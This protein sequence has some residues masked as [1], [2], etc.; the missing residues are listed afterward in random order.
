[1]R[2]QKEYGVCS[3]THRVYSLMVLLRLNDQFP[4]LLT[5]SV[6]GD[7]Y[8][9]LAQVRDAI[10]ASQFPDGHWPS[11]WPDGADAVAHPA[12]DDLSK[13]VIA[14]GH[15]L[16]WLAIAPKD[17]HP[18][19]EQIRKAFRW[20]IDTTTAQTRKEILDR[21]TFFSHVGSAGA[22]W[23]STTPVEFQK[24]HSATAP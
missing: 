7:V 6:R 14:T 4:G 24:T 2:G 23:R 15:H 19:E 8:N 5:E 3:G 17:L 10:T 9:Y 20:A 1:M 18:P 22:L 21:Y 16:E 13:T 11:N 12:D